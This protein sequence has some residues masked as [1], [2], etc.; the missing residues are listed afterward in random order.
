MSQSRPVTAQIV[1]GRE[2]FPLFRLQVRCGRT[3]RC[4]CIIGETEQI[5]HSDGAYGMLEVRGMTE[6]EIDAL[7]GHWLLF[8]DI[9]YWRDDAGEFHLIK[10]K[11]WI[12]PQGRFSSIPVGRRRMPAELEAAARDVVVGRLRAGGFDETADT[13]DGAPRFYRI[14]GQIVILPAIVHCARCGT[15][16]T[17]H[18]PSVEQL[19]A[20]HARLADMFRQAESR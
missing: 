10:P 8:H 12:M 20:A 18:P 2:A 9:G 16:N 3:R 13:L 7:L 19:Q 11:R 6:L 17:V 15:L 5:T 1:Y 14:R 4:P